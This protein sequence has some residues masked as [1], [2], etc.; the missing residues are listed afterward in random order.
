MR[1]GMNVVTPEM[2]HM[3]AAGIFSV[4]DG[5]GM[6]GKDAEPFVSNVCK[7]AAARRVRFDEDDEEDT[8]WS[9]NKHWALPTAI[10]AGAFLVG[11]DAGRNGR[12]DRNHI[13]NVGSLL[14][15]RVKAILGFPNSSL[16][17]SMTRVDKILP[18]PAEPA[19][20]AGDPYSNGMC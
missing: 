19:P 11:A 17:R 10:G 9:R 13:S 16:W 12:P 5:A 1:D 20:T 7:A 8:W 14:W 15:E 6:S 4:A 18:P 2:A 3:F